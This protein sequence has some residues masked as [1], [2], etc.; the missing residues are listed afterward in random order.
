MTRIAPFPPPRTPAQRPAAVRVTDL[1]L[2][3]AS[4]SALAPARLIETML[5]RM[6][7]RP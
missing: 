5:D 7:C 6:E 2:M 3:L 4:L 1:D